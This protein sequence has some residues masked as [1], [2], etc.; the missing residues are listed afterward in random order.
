M[1]RNIKMQFTEDEGRNLSISLPR[2]DATASGA[3]TIEQT[4][5]KLRPVN[6]LM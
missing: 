3:S 1:H 4:Y 5:F 6:T 2:R